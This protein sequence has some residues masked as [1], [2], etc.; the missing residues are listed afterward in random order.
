MQLALQEGTIHRAKEAT[1]ASLAP[2]HPTHY[3]PSPIFISGT[4]KT[5]KDILQSKWISKVNDQWESHQYG[6]EKN[7]EIWCIGTDGGGVRSKAVNR[8][9]MLRTL[10][11]SSPIHS[12]LSPLALMNLQCGPIDYTVDIDYKHL[13]KRM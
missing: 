4:C 5:E 12:L 10:Q 7:S 2:F 8:F 13:Y 3:N 1:V 6:Q 9:A 11:L